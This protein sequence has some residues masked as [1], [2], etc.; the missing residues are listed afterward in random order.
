MA[1]E[2]KAN[3]NRAAKK[4]TKATTKR[5]VKKKT[6]AAPKRTTKSS[7]R[8]SPE[9]YEEEINKLLIAEDFEGAA[10]LQATYAAASTAPP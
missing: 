6:K 4:K 5:T 1:K 3:T 9:A 8:M 7:K 10:V 2:R